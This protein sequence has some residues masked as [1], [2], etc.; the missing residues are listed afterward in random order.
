MDPNTTTIM[1]EATW[2]IANLG[3]WIISAI[4]LAQIWVIALVKRLRKPTVE[5][6]ESG[7]IEIGFFNWGPT[8]G[9]LG[10]LRVLHKE[11]FVKTI[12]IRIT[13][14]KDGSAHLFNWRLFRSNTLFLDKGAPVTFEIASSFILRP[15]D[16]FKYNILFVDDAFIADIN[17]KISHLSRKW[18]DYKKKRIKELEGQYQ[19]DPGVLLDNPVVDELLY[20][21]FSDA[22]AVT[23]VYTTVDRACYWETGEYTLAFLVKCARPDKPFSKCFTFELSEDDVRILRLN[24]IVIVRSLCGFVEP[25]NFAYPEYREA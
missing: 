24:S 5:I 14:K 17:P 13:R 23:D 12:Q 3:P 21:E 11:I 9:L 7:N 18:A 20:D 4:A 15:E 25:W 10:T 16:S 1:P 6:Y 19:T 2:T 22:G 8:V